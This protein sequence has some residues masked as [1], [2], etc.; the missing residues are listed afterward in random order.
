MDWQGRDSKVTKY[1]QL[2]RAMIAH[3]LEI[4]TK[5]FSRFVSF[6]Y[7]LDHIRI[8]CCQVTNLGFPEYVMHS[9]TRVGIYVCYR[10]Y[11]KL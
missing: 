11:F 7:N 10:F 8:L 4:K 2:R 1:S 9:G 3:I 5:P 6:S